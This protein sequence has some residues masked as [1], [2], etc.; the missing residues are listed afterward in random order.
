VNVQNLALAAAAA[1][2]VW[3][4]LPLL[5]R[6]ANA[7][8]WVDPHPRA[9]I[10]ARK[11]G[12]PRAPTVGGVALLGVA[13]FAC[14]S[15][16]FVISPPLVVF[17]LTAFLA[18]WID[19]RTPGGLSPKKKVVA[20]LV[21]ALPLAAYTGA[22]LCHPATEHECAFVAV[23]RYAVSAPP[24]WHCALVGGVATLV[25]AFVCFNIVNTWDHA[26]GVAATFTAVAFASVGAP[27]IAGGA[28]GL[29]ARQLRPPRSGKPYLGDAGS[30]LVAALVLVTPA[31][32]FFLWLP[33]LDLVRV[34]AAR[35]ADGQSAFEGDRRHLGAALMGRGLSPARTAVLQ[36][37]LLAATA[38]ALGQH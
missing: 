24:S 5:A 29:L 1:L 16:A 12:Q 13:V 36:A 4:V 21:A 7:R 3:S 22:T 19:D 37:L 10:P 11:R 23:L 38:F 32:W 26:D 14:S 33:A 2:V 28:A 18:G 20:Q 17:V 31:T 9:P 8:G 30:H 34:V 25:L 6:V 35:L 27:L 15:G